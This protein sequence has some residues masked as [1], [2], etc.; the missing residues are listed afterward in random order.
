[1]YESSFLDSK[2]TIHTKGTRVESE[3]GHKE[4]P[5]QTFQV[6][7]NVAG[8]RGVGAMREGALEA[9]TVYLVRMRY[10]AMINTDCKIHHDDREFRILPGTL[11]IRRRAN[12]IQ[13]N[14]QEVTLG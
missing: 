14:M 3:F 10:N 13:F 12:E 7:A 5:G 2:I 1:M 6:W 4:I 9:Y 8:T 11:Q